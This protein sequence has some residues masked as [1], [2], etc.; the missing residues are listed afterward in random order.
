MY[1]GGTSGGTTTQSFGSGGGGGTQTAGGAGGSNNAG[2]FGQGGQGLSASGGYG[3]AGGGGWYGGGGSYPDG[4][5]DDDRGGGGGSGY[6]YTSSTASNY[7]SGCLL[8]SSYYLTDGR[9]IAGNTAFTSPTG[10]SETGHTG[11]GYIRITVIKAGSGNTL[12]KTTSNTWKK[13]KQMFINT[14]ASTI[15]P[16]GLV[17]LEY[18][19]STGTQYINT[20]IIPNGNT[21]VECKFIP[22][23]TK[24]QAI[25]C[26]G[27]T[28]VS[29]TNT[30]SNTMFY[31]SQHIRRD[32]FGSSKTSSSTYT[33]GTIMT[34]DANKN[35]VTINGST[36]EIANFTLSSTIGK[37]P[38]LLLCSAM[39]NTSSSTI[40]NLDNYAKFKIYYYKIYDN[41]TLVRDFVPA[42][43]ISDDKCGLW[44][45]VNLKFYTDE[46][47]GNFTA[48]TEKTTIAAIGTPIEY[49]QS[50]G[51]QYIDTGILG[52]DIKNVKIDFQ[53]TSAQSRAEQE[54]A[55]LYSGGRDKLQIGWIDSSFISTGGATY[56]QTTYSARTIANAMPIGSPAVTLYLFAQ[57][58]GNIAKYNSSVKIYSCVIT[59][60]S[61]IIY[62]FIPIKTTTNIY[63]L[64]D[65]VNKVFYKNAGTGTFTG[66]P[67]ITLTGWHKI[68]GAWTKINGTTW[69]QVL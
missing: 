8:N 45:K 60:T 64:W 29:G 22:L 25:F 23:D 69:K 43:R 47:G 36:S 5:G 49:I 66:G 32:Y 16:S 28:A 53:F 20:S 38:I 6:V 59:T 62:N 61:G 15:V 39:Y 57:H 7:P 67:A 41:D 18:I 56:S 4:S 2:T 10:T 21:R 13:Q 33:T 34:I 9:T 50:S 42:K 11:N 19:E 3:G 58:E 55:A 65:K 54:V 44:D 30:Y 14:G 1:G 17:E 63:G 68:K 40:T 48:G 12:V 37:M 46:N 26:G 31:V 24:T 27:R 51:T 35:I 52:T